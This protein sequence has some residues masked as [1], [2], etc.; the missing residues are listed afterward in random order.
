M[1]GLGA[2]APSGERPTLLQIWWPVLLV[3]A[4]GVAVVVV[5]VLVPLVSFSQALGDY[6]LWPQQ[7]VPCEDPE[8]GRWFA[9]G[10][11]QVDDLRDAVDAGI[12]VDAGRDGWTPL[13]CAASHG[14]PAVVDLL[15]AAGAD[16]DLAIGGQPTPLALAAAAGDG[17]SIDLL[18]RAGADLDSPM[19][20]TTP[21]V[22]AATTD[23]VDVLEQLLAAGAAVDAPDD[24]GA[25]A[26]VHAAGGH[27]ESV[28]VLLEHGADPGAE[29]DVTG[30]TVRAELVW[31]TGTTTWSDTDVLG[32]TE[33]GRGAFGP[34]HAAALSGDV[35]SLEQLLAAGA[36]PDAVAFGAYGPVHLAVLGEQPAARRALLEAGAD[37][38][39]VHDP[40]VG[41]A[42][43]LRRQATSS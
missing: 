37:E 1:P 28:A 43:D 35:E 20:G 29:G 6:E 11:G 40:R 41:S 30:A 24:E 3:A 34:L 14:E 21:L 15:L 2:P 42:A 26:L 27:P 8:S 38:G 10:T 12:D 31:R 5:L 32:P 7:R 9:A 39:A 36:D 18:V 16:P 13:L 4:G 19:G 22:E 23:H 33:Q 17:P 25:T